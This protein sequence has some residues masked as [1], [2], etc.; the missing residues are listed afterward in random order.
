MLQ[1]GSPPQPVL[2][3]EIVIKV[4]DN[5]QVAI[6]VGGGIS[7]LDLFGVLGTVQSLLAEQYKK[8]AEQQIQAAPPGLINRLIQ[9]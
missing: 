7:Q 2:V 6:N 3:A 1:N 5:G 9:G 8:Q 4:L